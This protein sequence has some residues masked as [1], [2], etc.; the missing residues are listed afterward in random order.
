MSLSV[1]TEAQY[2]WAALPSGREAHSL[3]L[4]S[5][6]GW[7]IYSLSSS[8]QSHCRWSASSCLCFQFQQI[9]S[10]L[11][12]LGEH[13]VWGPALSSLGFLHAE[14]HFINFFSSV[15][16][17][18]G[19]IMFFPKR[20]RPILQILKSLKMVTGGRVERKVVSWVLKPS[21]GQCLRV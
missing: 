7:L 13:P 1:P 5:I 20:Y 21:E 11:L 2:Q 16:L 17:L 18:H 6:E 3:D 15:N 19:A 14:D 8:L 9:L 10:P 4:G 12:C